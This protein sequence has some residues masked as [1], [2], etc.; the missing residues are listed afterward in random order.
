MATPFKAILCPID[1]D[2]NSMIALDKAVELARQFGSGLVVLHVLPLVLS[3]GGVPP[4]AAMYEDQEKAAR[5]KLVNIA[6]K[7]LAG[8][9]FEL[10]V[11]TGDVVGCILNAQHEHQCDLVVMATHGHRGIARLFLGSVAEAIVRKASCP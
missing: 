4:P 2:E 10:H 3:L 6:K 7:N 5:A 1:F 9:K 8:L 11:Y